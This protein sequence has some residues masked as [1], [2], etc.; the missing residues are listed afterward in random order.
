MKTVCFLVLINL[1]L[2]R[3]N[4]QVDQSFLK[5]QRSFFRE[6]VLP[7][8]T[9]VNIMLLARVD[10]SENLEVVIDKFSDNAPDYYKT[11]LQRMK[12]DIDLQGLVEYLRKSEIKNTQVYIPVF[13]TSSRS[14]CQPDTVSFFKK[15]EQVFKFDKRNI[16]GTCFFY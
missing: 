12:N 7:L 15:G 2:S 13:F 9:C 1:F 4:G 10:V 5:F 16:S 6:F 3:T 14:I 11:E 8:D